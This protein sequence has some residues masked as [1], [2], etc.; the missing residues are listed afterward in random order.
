MQNETTR[1]FIVKFNKLNPDNKRYVIAVQQALVFA[2][3]SSS[4]DNKLSK[5]IQIQEY[6]NENEKK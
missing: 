1:D 4:E 5:D 2:Q 3:L 6:D